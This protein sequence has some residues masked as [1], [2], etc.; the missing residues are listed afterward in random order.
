MCTYSGRKVVIGVG[1]CP[2]KRIWT[3]VR[4]A[5]DKDVGVGR[6]GDW[7]LPDRGEAPLE[8][9]DGRVARIRVHL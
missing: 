5:R 9:V 4:R 3:G 2:C 6:L 8:D 1:T 7:R